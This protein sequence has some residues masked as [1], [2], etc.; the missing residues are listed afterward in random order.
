ML[1]PSLESRFMQ[2]FSKILAGYKNSPLENKKRSKNKKNLKTRFYKK[3]N[4][5]RKKRFLHL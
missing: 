3:N 5:K 4:K 1:N 2:E